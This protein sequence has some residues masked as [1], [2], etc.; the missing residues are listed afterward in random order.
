MPK[1]FEESRI[2]ECK[3]VLKA[4]KTKTQFDTRKDTIKRLIGYVDKAGSDEEFYAIAWNDFPV[5]SVAFINDDSGNPLFPSLWQIEYA[6]KMSAKKYVW[7]MCSRKIGK[8]TLLSVKN[9]HDMC[10]L[11]PKRIVCFAP[12]LK[13]DFV[14]EKMGKYLDNSPYLKEVFVGARGSITKDYIDL[15]N[16]SSCQNKTIGLA[17]KGELTRGEYGDIVTV[18]EVQKIEAPV[19]RQVIFP[20]IADAY[21]EKKFRMLGTPNLYTNPNLE[22]EW[23]QWKK[24][25]EGLE[26]EYGFM[27]VDWRRGVREGCLDEKYVLKEQERMTPDEF[28]MEYEAGFPEQGSRFFDSLLLDS[29]MDDSYTFSNIRNKDCAYCMSVDW[30]TFVNRTQII[31]GEFEKNTKTLRYIAWKEIDPKRT[32]LDY[33]N[34][35][36][37]VKSMFYNYS[38]EWICPD[39]TSNQDALIRMLVSGNNSIPEGQLYKTGD[40]LGYVATDVLNDQMWRNHKQQMVKGRIKVPRGGTVE[41][42]FFEA[43]KK[44]HN[45]LDV[46]VIR[47]GQMIKLEEPK[48]GYKDLAVACGMLSLAIPF[49][50]RGKAFYGLD[51]W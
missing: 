38:C 48:N 6:R 22:R 26:S 9:L 16:G 8:S 15:I 39:A 18:D 44:E 47:N 29:C 40:R 43:W 50:D 32:K 35:I 25:S 12:T 20:I 45:E 24:D 11:V 28:M 21:S 30:A 41:K 27:Q 36:E 34:Q 2:E 1:L 33:E 51:G 17:T 7:A 23:R 19:M 14:F 46:K 49:Y 5:W 31:V 10:G 4:S 37:I 42:R 13:Q 3:R